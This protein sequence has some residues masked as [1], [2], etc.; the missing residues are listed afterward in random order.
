MKITEID[1]N[2]VQQCADDNTVWIDSKSEYFKIYG[3][4]YDSERK[5][6]RR[7]PYEIAEKTNEG[8]AILSKNTAGGRIKFDTNSLNISIKCTFLNNGIMTH[9]PLTGSNGFAVY[10]NGIFHVKFSPEW[11]IFNSND[12]YISF[13][14]KAALPKTE[15]VK[16]VEIYFPLYGGVSELY[17]G[18][19]DNCKI[20]QASE[21][22]YKNPIVYYGSSITQ[23]G[24]A[25]R[26]GNDYQGHIE[27]WLNADYVNLGFSGSC[28]GEIIMADYIISLCPSV[29]VMDYDHNAPDLEH[30]KKTHYPFYK[31]IRNAIPDTPIIFITKPDYRSDEKLNKP[32][33]EVIRNT[34]LKSI[35]DGDKLTEFIDGET[36]FGIENYDACTVDGCHPND[37]GFYRMAKIICPFVKKFIK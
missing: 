2:F 4:F 36:L 35:K 32:R 27:R 21:Y 16:E 1:K 11:T 20:R 6:F 29:V 26:P 22:K 9:M 7:V 28:M 30:L 13:T 12:K 34:Y 23:G 14:A 17:I 10:I 33:R 24:C 37:L 5:E 8:V 15:N 25:S 3:V 31:R 18:I 19:D